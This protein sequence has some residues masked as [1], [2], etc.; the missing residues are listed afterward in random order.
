[1]PTLV[2]EIGRQYFV[3]CGCDPD[4]GP[5]VMPIRLLVCDDHEVV[6]KGIRFLIKPEMDIQIV[7][8]AK[9]GMEA[10]RLTQ[11]TQPDVALLDVVMPLLD[12]F[13][14]LQRIRVEHPGVKVVIY[15][16][17]SNSTF[18]SRATA[19]GASAFVHKEAPF[20]Q[21]VETIRHAAAG[22]LIP[23]RDRTRRNAGASIA[24]GG[25]VEIDAPLTQR[26]SEVLVKLT[27]GLTNKQIATELHISYET[28]KE[29]V[30]H[31]LR[32]IGVTDRTQA[33]VWAVR[34]AL[35]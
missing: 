19:L 32:K 14:T 5:Q 15:S 18:S 10:L 28:V 11:E 9:D 23:N 29:H 8:E 30:Q 1:L 22:K 7:A 24:S 17:F 6:R 33:A 21:L 16:G 12:G 3:D 34:K 25:E 35:P 26:E 2:S 20:S 13:A 4:E 31:V 27:E